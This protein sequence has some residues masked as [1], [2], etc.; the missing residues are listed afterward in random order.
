MVRENTERN[1]PSQAEEPIA[2][3]PEYISAFIPTCPQP[4]VPNMVVKRRSINIKKYLSRIF[5]FIRILEFV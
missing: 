1:S 5:I 2:P 4:I 3:N